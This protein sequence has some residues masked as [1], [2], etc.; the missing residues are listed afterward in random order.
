MTTSEVHLIQG[1][2]SKVHI[3]RDRERLEAGVWR[4]RTFCGGSLDDPQH[5][6]GDVWEAE[7]EGCVRKW[8]VEA[9]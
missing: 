6:T 5:W 7:C 9:V 8:R 3:E 4:S 1:T 2:R